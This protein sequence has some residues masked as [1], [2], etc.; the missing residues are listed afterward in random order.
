MEGTFL[1]K[2]IAK[3]QEQLGEIKNQKLAAAAAGAAACTAAYVASPVLARW[4][5]AA[6]EKR[7]RRLAAPVRLGILGAARI[8]VKNCKAIEAVPG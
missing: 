3:A 6:A 2:T 4:W 8:A 5:R 7:R 1:G